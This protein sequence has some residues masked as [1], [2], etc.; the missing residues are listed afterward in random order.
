MAKGHSNPLQLRLYEQAGILISCAA[1]VWR[2][3][4][5]ELSFHEPVGRKAEL[6]FLAEM[7]QLSLFP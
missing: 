5:T 1:W 2:F 3:S 6:S 7:P 4:P